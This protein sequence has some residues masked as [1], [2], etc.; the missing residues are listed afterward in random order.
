[1]SLPTATKILRG[2]FV[3]TGKA[4]CSIFE[5]GLMVY[6]CIKDSDRYSLDYFSIDNF[7]IDIFSDRGLIKTDGA[8]QLFGDYDFWVFNWHFITMAAHLDPAAIAKLPG[9]KFTIVLELAPDDPL[10]LVPPNVFDGYIALDPTAEPTESI[11]PFPRPLPGKPRNPK[12]TGNVIPVIGSF[13]F[14][15]PGKGFE[16]LVEAV[17]RE[18]DQA[19][20]RINI[21]TGDYVFTDSMH[22]QAY[23]QYLAKTC[24]RI[25]KPGIEVRFTYDFMGPDEL[26]D[27]CE[28]NDLNCFM[29]TRCQPGLSATTDQAIISG[30][31]LLTLSN[32]TFRHI[33]KYIPPYPVW[34]LRDAMDRSVPS[35]RRLQQDWST[36]A[37]GQTFHRMLGAFGLLLISPRENAASA[38]DDR[39]IIR[40]MVATGGGDDV[41]DVLD[42]STRVADALGRTGEYEVVR[43]RVADASELRADIDLV[44]PA[45]IVLLDFPPNEQQALG[46]ALKAIS[47]SKIM[48][49]DER[50]PSPSGD[51]NFIVIPRQP[52][53]PFFTVLIPLKPA[54]IWLI[55]FDQDP[56][57]LQAMLAKI[58]SEMPHAA[59]YVESPVDRLKI[60]KR[61]TKRL[62]VKAKAPAELT[63]EVHPLPQKGSD[64]INNLAAA[65]LVVFCH[66]PSRARELENISSLA[67]STERAV[68][69]TRR[70]PFQCYSTATFVEDRSISDF[71]EAGVS[72][73]MSTVRDFGEW[74]FF[75]NIHELFADA[76][77]SSQSRSPRGSGAD[78]QRRLKI[79][80]TASELLDLRGRPFLEAA[81]L[82]ILGRPADPEGVTFYLSALERGMSKTTILGALRSSAEGR[83]YGMNLPGMNRIQRRY[84]I[85]RLPLIGHVSRYFGWDDIRRPNTR[86]A[87]RSLET[88]LH[89]L[90]EEKVAV[91]SPA[92][93][94]VQ[95]QVEIIAARLAEPAYCLLVGCTDRPI[96]PRS[97]CIVAR[98]GQTWHARGT[99][100]RLVIWDV[101]TKFF[102]LITRDE[103]SRFGLA[104]ALAALAP[105][106]AE[107]NIHMILNTESCGDTDWLIVPDSQGSLGEL[108]DLTE[109]NIIMAARRVGLRSAFLFSGAE[110]L[111][112]VECEG[113][114]ASAHE[115]YMQALLL[116]D[117]V[118]GDSS[119]AADD[120]GT[121]LTNHQYA[122]FG[123]FIRHAEYPDFTSAYQSDWIRYCRLLSGYLA[124]SVDIIRSNLIVYIWTGSTQ[125]SDNEFTDRIV[126]MMRARGVAVTAVTWNA[127]LQALVPSDAEPEP[128][129]QNL[130]TPIHEIADN[131]SL[132][133]LLFS[134]HHA[135]DLANG[136]I[137]YCSSKGI[138]T[139][140]LVDR[141]GKDAN[142]IDFLG[143][144]KVLFG[145]EAT[146][147]EF[148]S[149]LLGIRERV[150]GAEKRF[151]LLALPHEMP[152]QP[153]SKA[154]KQPKPDGVHFLVILSGNEQTDRPF[155]MAVEQVTS[156]PQ[157]PAHFTIAGAAEAIEQSRL[158]VRNGGDANAGSINWNI[159]EDGQ[160]S[161]LVA[162]ADCAI[163]AG[164]GSAHAQL[165]AECRWR[166][167]PVLVDRSA[168]PKTDDDAGTIGLRAPGM[169]EIVCAIMDLMEPRTRAH[170]AH[171]IAGI[172]LRSWDD[173]ADELLNE[174]TTDRLRDRI[175]PIAS[176][177]TADVYKLFPNL[178]PRPLLSI[179]ISTYNRSGWVKLNLENIFSQ[180]PEE[181]ADLEVLVIDN[182]SPDDTPEV[183]KPYLQRMDFRSVRNPRN[184]GML[185][186]LAV[187]A[188][189]ARGRYMWILGDD[190][191]IRPGFIEK[192]LGFL[193][194]D[195]DIGLVYLNYGYSSEDDPG[196]IDRAEYLQS[197]N[198]LEP[199]SPD[200]SAD[201][202]GLSA[203]SENFY[204]AIYSHI[205]RRDHGMRAY[206]QDTSERPFSTMLSCIPTAYYVLNYMADEPAHWIGE[207]V[208]V[209]NSNVSWTA[210]GTL[211]DLEQLPRAWDLA[212]RMGAPSD[213]IDKRRA[214]RL[215]LMELMWREMFEADK[216]GNSPYFSAPRVLMR[217]KHLP[218]ID[219]RIPVL[220][221]IYERAYEA[222]H[223]AATL[224]PEELF[225]AWS[226]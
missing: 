32:D 217:V 180:L 128:G 39:K 45:G 36:D 221:E 131:R 94:L 135:A 2:A 115:Q 145:E 77:T 37:F 40:I 220:K 192:I 176:A 81:Y 147:E 167:I 46:E 162:A 224:L 97:A 91:K 8:D 103:L 57:A 213:E 164:S 1:M 196:R 159:L 105:A 107:D 93:A 76:S 114:A 55:G 9:L 78:T 71:M 50:D 99:P 134:G 216:A 166:A 33:H 118:I 193:A 29:Y 124:E 172:A 200:A 41:A 73:Q 3:N 79:P 133:W 155:L 10:K 148:N 89:R 121:F 198:E 12:P 206:T 174:L 4:N 137:S 195:Q 146:Y 20:V 209:V 106:C 72:A 157:I 207:Q 215:W 150:I 6:N 53:V 83:A 90:K 98:L 140:A 190:D 28:A 113:A 226:A 191:L 185:G 218:E 126:A 123:P 168:N 122:T 95:Q 130:S 25:A 31:P 23:A 22:Q 44:Q 152:G 48:L 58:G 100:I 189:R 142:W 24:A 208:M 156:T 56:G 70:A 169:S 30:R 223:P 59:V 165:R 84:R 42:Y 68:L 197:F 144:D 47:G 179:C 149:F 111:K 143:L 67:L 138:R 184:V 175:I 171:E 64:I 102:R 183:V 151:K 14:G 117:V 17:N 5:S 203:K 60:V 199:V 104:E 66:N 61:Q 153:R 51:K 119:Q 18:F 182:T 87:L 181:R 214:N 204:T 38:A 205:Y 92:R 43:A 211:F 129:S 160:A 16:L 69:F 80:S 139:S 201:V 108:P 11:F 212:E 27:W 65:N 13:G 110:P 88:Q 19:V 26:V 75:A 54:T 194:S 178:D 127:E 116:A 62:I 158:H 15:T 74:Q 225:K 177:A 202:K 141:S 86:R 188:Q 125:P 85:S 101:Q 96:T 170:L 49:I 34:S 109:M 21:P 210:Y 222:G 161:A 7:D 163:F 186:N 63:V 187:T 120:L 132:K 82:S 219:E 52:I 112:N 35:V 173:Y 154:P 136:I